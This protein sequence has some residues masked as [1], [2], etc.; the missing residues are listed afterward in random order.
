MADEK[1][2]ALAEQVEF[3]EQQA[4]SD[5]NAEREYI[6]WLGEEPYGT[7]FIHSHTL[8][9]GDGLWKRAGLKVN[10]DVTWERDPFGPAVG[11]PGNRFLVPV[12]DLP[13]GV[14]EVLEKVPGYKRVTA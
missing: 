2:T 6:E 9:R 13:N 8:P 1:Q 5:A 7:D 14:A 3:E 4:A 10:K 12:E 11:Q